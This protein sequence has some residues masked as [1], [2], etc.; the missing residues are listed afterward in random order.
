MVFCLPSIDTSTRIEFLGIVIDIEQS[1]FFQI[2]DVR[3]AEVKLI[4]ASCSKLKIVSKPRLLKIIGK[5]AFSKGDVQCG[6]D[7]LSRLIGLAK[8]VKA[9]YHRV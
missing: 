9:L 7:F 4:V 2:S 1:F 5:I 6:R 8:S 3:I